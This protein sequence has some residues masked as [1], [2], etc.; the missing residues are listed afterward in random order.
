[1]TGKIPLI[2]DGY[3]KDVLIGS[4]AWF[5]WLKEIH[6]FRYESTFGSFSAVKEAKKS[7]IYWTAH[8][9]IKGK[10]RREYMGNSESLTL[11]KLEDTALKL[12]DPQYWEKKSPTLQ[13]LQSLTSYENNSLSES[14]HDQDGDASIENARL[15]QVKTTDQETI[16]QQANLIRQLQ[17]EIE[18]VKSTNQTLTTDLNF[19]REQYAG[20]A[21]EKAQWTQNVTNNTSAQVEITNL[22]QEIANL[23]QELSNRAN[24]KGS[25]ISEDD[26]KLN[27]KQDLYS[28]VLFRWNL[29]L[30]GKTRKTHPRYDQ[31]L[32]LFDEILAWVKS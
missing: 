4:E 29:K 8:R 16:D 32:Q 11:T 2:K 26:T 21:S 31:A 25:E 18:L 9:R 19:Y 7:G 13:R 27:P 15:D 28:N 10:L 1:M 30:A 12:A 14:N 3:H 6:S 20:L 22:K 17:S 24:N 23:K 5:D